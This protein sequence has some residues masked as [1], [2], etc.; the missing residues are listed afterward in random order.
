MPTAQLAPK[1]IS[2]ISSPL[3]VK[4]FPTLLAFQIQTCVA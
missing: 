1:S 3:L 2:S 4:I